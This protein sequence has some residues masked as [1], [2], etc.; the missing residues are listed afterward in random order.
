MPKEGDTLEF[1]AWS[2]TERLPFVVYADFEALLLKTDRRYGVNTTAIHKHH[3]MS[4]GYLV[5]AAEGVPT[6]LFEQFDIP[7][8]PVIFRGSATEDDVAARFVRAVIDVADKIARLYKEVNVPIIMSVEDCRVHDSKT[9][10]DLCGCSFGEQNCK[11][12]HHDHLSGRFLKT[13]CNTCN[14]K[15]KTPK[16]VP[17]FLHN[18]SN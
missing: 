1:K 6:N 14:L 18:L 16:F 15:L 9:L 2:K 13:L 7:R 4:Y 10:C 8:A 12:A 3:P 17:C 5:V 11:T